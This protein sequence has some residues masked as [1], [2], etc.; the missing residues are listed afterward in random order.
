MAYVAPSTV[1]AGTSPITAA[2][3][4]IIVNDILDHE[5]RLAPLAPPRGVMAYATSTLTTAVTTTNTVYLTSPSFTAVAGRLYKISY[6]DG[7]IGPTGATGSVIITLRIHLTNTAGTQYGYGNFP[8]AG[9]GNNTSCFTSIITTL[10]AG[11]TII[12]GAATLSTGS[13]N[14]GGGITSWLTVEDIGPA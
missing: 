9:S 12:V 7:G 5:S 13:A 2:A 6:Y 11:S 8:S 10:S 1:T 14:R 4:N 3:H